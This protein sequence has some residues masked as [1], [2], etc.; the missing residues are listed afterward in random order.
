M[1]CPSLIILKEEIKSFVGKKIL[2]VSGN[3]SIKKERFKNKHWLIYKK[4]KCTRCKIPVIAKH[5]GKGKRYSFF[6]EI[7]QQKNNLTI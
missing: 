6:C 7:C 1:K 5:T 3:T 2:A 4:K